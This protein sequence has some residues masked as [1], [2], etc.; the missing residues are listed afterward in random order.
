M[1]CFATFALQ[2]S[3][4]ISRQTLCFNVTSLVYFN[5]T[6]LMQFNHGIS[7]MV[8]KRHSI[9]MALINHQ[10]LLKM[11]RHLN[12]LPRLITLCINN[13]CLV[14]YVQH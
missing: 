8:E 6:S 9:C 2:F 13:N 4:L 12:P 3:A 7:G 11:G 10:S 14:R 1:N 5:D